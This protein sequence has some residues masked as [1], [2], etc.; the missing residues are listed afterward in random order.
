MLLVAIFVMNQVK[1]TIKYFMG[2]YH[3]GH[4]QEDDNKKKKENRNGEGSQ[5]KPE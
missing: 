2:Y 4:E 1:F 5:K 3:T